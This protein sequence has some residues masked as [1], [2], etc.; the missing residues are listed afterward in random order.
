MI[1]GSHCYMWEG[2]PCSNQPQPMFSQYLI[3]TSVSLNMLHP[4]QINHDQIAVLCSQMLSS[5]TYT[6]CSNNPFLWLIFI[7]TCTV[8]YNTKAELRKVVRRSASR[9][10]MGCAFLRGP[11]NNGPYF[12]NSEEL[13]DLLLWIIQVKVE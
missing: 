5:V 13:F 11:I 7:L 8:S 3:T 12:S 4:C 9:N 2:H 1:N 6:G 10:S